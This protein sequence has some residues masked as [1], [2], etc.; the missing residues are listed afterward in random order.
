[1][2]PNIVA[3]ALTVF[4]AFLVL[5]LMPK[6]D[7]PFTVAVC[8]A[9]VVAAAIAFLLSEA[10][11]AFIALF[12][13]LAVFGSVSPR[14]A[15][16]LYIAVMAALPAG[17]VYDV[18]MIGL[19]YLVSLD[20]Q[21]L[22]ALVLLGPAFV[23]ALF[24]RAPPHFRG[25]E[26]LLLFFVLFTGVM[27]F[28]DLPFTSVLRTIFDLFVLVYLPYIAISRTLVTQKDIDWALRAL[29]AS[30]L[31]LA[32][33][34]VISTLRHWNYYASIGDSSFGKAYFDV[35]NGLLRVGA[36]VIPSLLAALT[37]A[38]I[39]LA[40][41]LK[42]RKQI[43]PLFAYI[44]IGASGLTCFATGARGGWLAAIAC[45]GAYFIFYYGSAALRRLAYVAAIICV[46]VGF[47]LI[48]SDSDVL[49]DEYG[50]MNYRAELIRTSVA[51]IQERP[52]FGSS[53]IFNLPRFQHLRQGEGII[54][55]VNAYIQIVLFYGMV[56]LG[57][58]VGAHAL[59]AA[60]ALKELKEL[61]GHRELTP[62]QD[63]QRRSLV[64]LIA[65]Q[66]GYLVLIGTISLVGQ[67]PHYGY[68]ILAVL[69]AQARILK[70]QRLAASQP[71]EVVDQTDDI[72][73]APSQTADSPPMPA[74]SGPVPYGARFVRR[75]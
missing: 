54:D 50:T 60:A 20:Y 67:V 43:S 39:V 9:W 31:L 36:T 40:F 17:L 3:I 73:S 24:S 48:F 10:S 71:D 35:R 46:I 27:S 57:A 11:V 28:R 63:E 21:K 15:V 49:N 64:F 52:L 59:G 69:I 32:M 41:M 70:T 29:F 22:A 37:A 53:D 61:P 16:Y 47:N 44:C 55:L 1:M 25:V 38:G 5:V 66:G 45:I 75:R 19:N 33:I 30:F 4:A 56:G 68:L 8:G 26:N 65:F 42:A 13:M 12:I 74:P 18:P 62:A 14:G 58:L 23:K 72:A 7:K 2:N 34:G 6:E 51:Q